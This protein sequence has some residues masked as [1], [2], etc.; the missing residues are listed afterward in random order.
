MSDLD[1]QPERFAQ[2]DDSIVVLMSVATFD[3]KEYDGLKIAKISPCKIVDDWGVTLGEFH[4]M[5]FFSQRKG[6]ESKLF[7]Q[8]GKE[9]KQFDFEKEKKNGH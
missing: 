7:A 1:I 6:I 4:P 3:R 2:D 9:L 8:I 5:V